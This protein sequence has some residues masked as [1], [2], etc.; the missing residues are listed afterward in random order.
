MSTMGNWSTNL[1]VSMTFLSLVKLI[2]LHSTF[3]LFAAFATGSYIT[4]WMFLPETG[5]VSLEDVQTRL[6]GPMKHF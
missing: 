1:L 3:F 4:I 2:G 5:G 6:M